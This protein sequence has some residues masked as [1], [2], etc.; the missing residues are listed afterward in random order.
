M[1]IKTGP[2]AS[3]G[4]DGL[5]FVSTKFVEGKN[6]DWPDIEMHMV[7]ADVVADGGRYFKHLAGLTDQ[8][9]CFIIFD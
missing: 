7:P 1:N 9:S 2:L 3:T 4:V 8:V 6:L 5:A